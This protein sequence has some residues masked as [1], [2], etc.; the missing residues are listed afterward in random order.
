MMP[1]KEDTI[2]YLW[3]LTAGRVLALRDGDVLGDVMT[4]SV[5]NAP[6]QVI[7][8]SSVKQNSMSA[9]DVCGDGRMLTDIRAV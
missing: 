5:N 4:N 6:A 9:V 1:V 8:S 2:V 3:P 7:L